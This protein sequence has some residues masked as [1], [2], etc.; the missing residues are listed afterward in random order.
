[1]AVYKKVKFPDSDIQKIVIVEDVKYLLTM[2]AIF[3]EG[4]LTDAYPQYFEDSDSVEVSSEST[5]AGFAPKALYQK[6]ASKTIANVVG[7]MNQPV[8]KP[9]PRNVSETLKGVTEIE[10]VEGELKAVD[11]IVSEIDDSYRVLDTNSFRAMELDFWTEGVPLKFINDSYEKYHHD[12]K[13]STSTKDGFTIDSKLNVETVLEGKKRVSAP[14]Q[15]GSEFGELDKSTTYQSNLILSS[16]GI[17]L[18]SDTINSLEKKKIDKHSISLPKLID[19]EIDNRFIVEV[20]RL[21]NSITSAYINDMFIGSDLP[22][23]STS[24]PYN[25]IT[26]TSTGPRIGEFNAYSFV[27][28]GSHKRK[29]F[30]N[31]KPVLTD[32]L[33][34]GINEKYGAL[35][36][37]DVNSK[38]VYI[39]WNQE[40]KIYT[41]NEVVQVFNIRVIGKP[42]R[43]NTS[44]QTAKIKRVG[45]IFD[46][47]DFKVRDKISFIKREPLRS[48]VAKV[49]IK[50]S[51]LDT[52]K[53]YSNENTS[54]MR[55]IVDTR[56][57]FLKEKPYELIVRTVEHK[58]VRIE[59]L[60]T[61]SNGTVQEVYNL[62]KNIGE[63][64]RRS[65]YSGIKSRVFASIFSRGRRYKEPEVITS[66][67][68]TVHLDSNYV[69]T[70]NG[71]VEVFNIPTITS[72]K[73]LS[74]METKQLIDEKVYTTARNLPSKGSDLIVINYYGEKINI[75]SVL[76]DVIGDEITL[77]NISTLNTLNLRLINFIRSV[78][79]DSL[80]LKLPKHLIMPDV[81][82]GVIRS[83]NP[84]TFDENELYKRERYIDQ[85]IVKPLY[86]HELIKPSRITIKK[87][88]T[89]VYKRVSQYDELDIALKDAI[90]R[91]SMV[92]RTTFSFNKLLN[93][94]NGVYPVQ[95]HTVNEISDAIES[96]EYRPGHF[97]RNSL[98]S[99]KDSGDVLHLSRFNRHVL[100]DIDIG[101]K[102]YFGWLYQPELLGGPLGKETNYERPKKTV[103][104]NEIDNKA[105]GI[106]KY[107][108][109]MYDAEQLRNTIAKSTVFAQDLTGIFLEKTRPYNNLIAPIVV[110]PY[111]KIKEILY[112]YAEA[113][114][115]MKW[116]VYNQGTLL[117]QDMGVKN[118]VYSVISDESRFDKRHLNLI[119]SIK[120]LYKS[121]STITDDIKTDTFIL[122]LI[123]EKLY[124]SSIS[125][126]AKIKMK[127]S[128]TTIQMDHNTTLYTRPD[129]SVNVKY[130]NIKIENIIKKAIYRKKEINLKDYVFHYD[131]SLLL[132]DDL[133][134]YK[135]KTDVLSDRVSSYIR[136][137]RDSLKPI[138]VKNIS[139]HKVEYSKYDRKITL[140]NI[141]FYRNTGKSIDYLLMNAGFKYV[142]MIRRMYKN[143]VH[144]IDLNTTPSYLK[145]MDD[146]SK[147]KLYKNDAIIIEMDAVNRSYRHLLIKNKRVINSLYRHNGI[148]IEKDKLPASI[149]HLVKNSK[150][151]FVSSL[152]RHNAIIIEKDNLFYNIMGRLPSKYSSSKFYR[153]N[154]IIIE[155][156][157][158]SPHMKVQIKNSRGMLISSLFR[159]NGIIIE[160][161]S[162]LRDRKHIFTSAYKSLYYKPLTT[163][164]ILFTYNNFNTDA[165]Y[166]FIKKTRFSFTYLPNLTHKEYYQPVNVK[167]KEDKYFIIA[168]NKAIYKHSWDYKA[169]YEGLL[170]IKDPYKR[171][172]VISDYYDLKTRFNISKIFET[173]YSYNKSRPLV[174]K[175]LDSKS[176]VVLQY[177]SLG[178][179]WRYLSNRMAVTSRRLDIIYS[180][181]TVAKSTKRYDMAYD[182]TPKIYSYD[183]S[184]L[185][186]SYS[187]FFRQE[188]EMF[189]Y[190][191]LNYSTG[192]YKYDMQWGQANKIPPAIGRPTFELAFN[193]EYLLKHDEIFISKAG[194]R[195]YEISDTY[196]RD[197]K[198][199]VKHGDLPGRTPSYANKDAYPQTIDYKVAIP[200]GP[201]LPGTPILGS[202]IPKSINREPSFAHSNVSYS[203]FKAPIRK[204]I[205]AGIR[206]Y[207]LPDIKKDQPLPKNTFDTPLYQSKPLCSRGP[208]LG[209][210]GTIKTT[211]VHENSAYMLNFKYNDT[212][213]YFDYLEWERAQR[214][215]DKA[216]RC[217]NIKMP[218]FSPNRIFVKQRIAKEETADMFRIRGPY[219]W[220]SWYKDVKVYVADREPVS[221]AWDRRYSTQGLL[222]S[223]TYKTEKE[224]KIVLTPMKGP[225]IMAQ[226]DHWITNGPFGTR[227]QISG[228]YKN[229]AV[230]NTVY[231]VEGTS[232]NSKAMVHELNSNDIYT[233]YDLA[234]KRISEIK[235][236]FKDADI[237]MVVKST[238]HIK[239]G[240]TYPLAAPI[241]MNIKGPIQPRKKV[242]D[243]QYTTKLPE[244]FWRENTIM[245]FER[246]GDRTSLFSNKFYLQ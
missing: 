75:V 29:I 193:H 167:E 177:V 188:V 144:V 241:N 203:D 169:T 211:R 76:M 206:R 39:D 138:Y 57:I 52:I 236:R 226:V 179:N 95:Y 218:Q 181:I 114:V 165:E 107:L 80:Y 105:L 56:G 117:L 216:F 4:P 33:Y 44:Y 97:L 195:G 180:K 146:Y 59:R 125:D 153:S 37:I 103:I 77:T 246:D 154:A 245:V 142:D 13:L 47:L 123:K 113:P 133:R 197:I 63:F 32:D 23:T 36:V 215:D 161:D 86:Y 94:K 237:E 119:T 143:N 212:K 28:Q 202:I 102:E 194:L 65:F 90:T 235:A 68:G 84:L 224:D 222:Q 55:V 196:A 34:K 17:S 225:D 74:L 50:Q 46:V 190:G 121:S 25:V 234:N 150:G 159:H 230:K 204:G 160:K 22:V 2:G 240:S 71:L 213:Y 69:T 78:G 139:V 109:S 166:P 122:T 210:T 14:Y 41:G 73:T 147:G 8:T 148:I 45:K 207:T 38:K 72:G 227:F 92:V 233:S 53:K 93:R 185:K 9:K 244:N 11:L 66:V 15:F 106:S 3:E 183:R 220:P 51:D 19:G 112:S 214:E 134:L 111:D 21:D 35:Y 163:K 31:I 157:V 229:T 43:Y 115:L 30:Q 64:Y 171:K 155:K 49:Y 87:G 238:T 182:N 192:V 239:K 18:A 88:K 58:D 187:Y 231:T 98:P 7:E 126:I 81:K 176:D 54:Y 42:L 173:G 178:T 108:G 27:K 170:F 198:Y 131:Q 10:T 141:N 61:D 104:Q 221:Y 208:R 110:G 149:T 156:D 116:A 48:R 127:S 85:I 1:M 16:D 172:A 164:T 6:G 189:R 232:A 174:D 201:H 242:P 200:R 135:P 40:Y 223:N 89:S 82:G 26:L 151:A 199:S 12:T 137:V 120:S 158:L 60:V 186:K 132:S 70:S 243:W 145:Y 24:I 128:Y 83:P 205:F 91:P 130:S 118:T 168:D 175:L 79:K 99:D 152:Y 228:T 184:D 136:M 96:T 217:D 124:K 129:K 5:F 67:R 100:V 219:V 209:I 20:V 191:H 162:L 140:K 62:T 101:I